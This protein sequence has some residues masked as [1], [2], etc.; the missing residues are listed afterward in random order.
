MRSWLFV[1]GDSERK[2]EKS[3]GAGADVV[4]IDLEDSV[5]TDRKAAAR[6]IA[7]SAILTGAIGRTSTVYVRVNALD[8]G[9]TEADIK[10]VIAAAPAGIMLPKSAGGAD[11]TAL[12]SMLR[13][14]EAEA[15]LKDGSTAIAVVATETAGSLFALGTYAGASPRLS[16]MAW[17]GEDLAAELGAESNRREDGRYADAFRLARTLCLAGARHA[18]ALAIDT[19][20]TDFRDPDRLAAEAEAARRD[21]FDGKMAIHPDQVP[22]INRIFT[23]SSEAVAHAKRVVAA[24]ARDPA[25]GVV[26]IDGR[27]VDRPHLKQAQR[28]LDRAKRK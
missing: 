13:V 26:S 9:L 16:A 14:A 3:A 10:A 15:G 6:D 5:A 27:M 25:A 4:I 23:P 17:G 1:P 20:F 19:V 24:F 21:G 2:L 12:D 11:V 22:L 18:G 7:T 8:T 28:I